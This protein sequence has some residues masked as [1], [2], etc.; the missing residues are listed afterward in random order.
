M[1]MGFWSGIRDAWVPGSAH[2]AI[3]PTRSKDLMR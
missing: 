1:L 3:D 2:L